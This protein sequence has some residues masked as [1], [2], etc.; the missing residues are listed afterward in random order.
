[1]APPSPYLHSLYLV[2]YLAP[3]TAPASLQQGGRLVGS[4]GGQWVTVGGIGGVR[5]P[6]LTVQ[7]RR[8]A[9]RPPGVRSVYWLHSTL[10]WSFAV[11]FDD[12]SL[13]CFL[14]VQRCSYFWPLHVKR[15]RA[16]VDLRGEVM[17]QG[18]GCSDLLQSLP[19]RA[20]CSLARRDG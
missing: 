12:A 6:H 13:R 4:R 10:G 2:L 1:M 18:Y 14:Q 11:F 3:V 9:A 17:L 20:N 19:T 5:A 15:V 7:S 8:G 16:F